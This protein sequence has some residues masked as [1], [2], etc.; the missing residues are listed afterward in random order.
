MIKNILFINTGSSWRGL[1]KFHYKTAAKFQKKGYNI[2]VLAKKNTPFYKKCEKNKFNLEAIKHIGDITF[3]NPIRIYWLVNYLK[4]NNIDAMF[5]A[6]SSHF[7]YGSMAGKIAGTKKIIY[8]RAIAKPIKN[9]FYNRLFLKYFI[10]DFM[11]ISEI[12]KEKNLEKVPT[13]LL[14]DEKIKVIYKGVDKNNYRNIKIR[15]NIREEFNISP[16]DILITNIGR[17][18]R[19]KAQKYLL[20]AIPEVIKDNKSVKFLIVGDGKKEKEL[21]KL[22]KNLKIEDKVI[23]A[24]FRDDI[25]SILKQVD[26][27]A[28]T[29]IYEG[30]APWVILEAMMVGVPIVSTEALTI[31]E[32]VIDGETGYIAEDR[33]PKDIAKN[34]NKMIN[35][36]NR[37]QMG[38]KAAEIARKFYTFEKTISDI[39][40]KIFNRNT[41]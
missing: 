35:N 8:R 11:S 25:L 13:D 19:Q 33:N 20:K 31:S 3:I 40:E 32:F 28:H 1:E 36:K 4:K 38:K 16:N 6:Q 39:E 41:K 5:L 24:G 30:G 9:K 10:S 26:F 14:A 37:S 29:A 18:C 21:K 17:L 23:F 12:T 27:M 15:T 7:K 2:F 22:V 34:I